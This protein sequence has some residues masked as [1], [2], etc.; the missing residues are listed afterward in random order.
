[1]QKNSPNAN[2]KYFTYSNLYAET[3]L[4]FKVTNPVSCINWRHKYVFCLQGRN[5]SFEMYYFG[6][7]RLRQ[8]DAKIL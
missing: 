1:M 5:P 8:G 3:N 2:N 7:H 6:S 4:G